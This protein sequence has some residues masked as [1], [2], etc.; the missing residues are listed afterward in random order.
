MEKYGSRSFALAKALLIEM[1][2][3]LITAG[4]VNQQGTM[5]FPL[6]MVKTN[7]A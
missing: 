4:Q 6:A 1:D 2:Q 3:I 5:V 7:V